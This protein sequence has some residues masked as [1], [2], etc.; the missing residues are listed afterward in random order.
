M[1]SKLITVMKKYDFVNELK[2]HTHIIQYNKKNLN[3]KND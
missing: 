2:I 1:K 3:F